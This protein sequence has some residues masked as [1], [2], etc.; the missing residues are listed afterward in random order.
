METTILA[1]E[2]SLVQAKTYFRKETSLELTASR[3]VI[4]TVKNFCSW[5]LILE[6]AKNNKYSKIVLF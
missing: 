6:L 1:S 2:N 5:Y 4:L 3:L